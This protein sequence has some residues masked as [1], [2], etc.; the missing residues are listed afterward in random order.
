MKIPVLCLWAVAAISAADF[1]T[2]LDAYQRGDFAAAMKE[3]QP[4]A[5]AGD[6]QAQYNLGLLYARGQ[7]VSQDYAKAAQWYEK[8]AVQGVPAAQYNLGVMYAN[9][10]GV[11]ANPEQAAKWFLKAAEQGVQRRADGAREHLPGGRGRVPELCGGRE[12]VPEGGRTGSRA[13]GVPTRGDVRP[14]A[15]RHQ[16]L[17]GSDR[18][19]IRRRPTAATRARWRTSASSTTTARA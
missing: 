1:K 5:D 10:Q 9:G 3:W 7:G 16:G 2:G 12:V 17:R 13:G 19:G 15:G 14:R 11:A 18:S 6:P 8:A 4:I